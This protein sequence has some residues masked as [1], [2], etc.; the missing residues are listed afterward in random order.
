[1]WFLWNLEN[2]LVTWLLY[3]T[4]VFLIRSIWDSDSGVLSSWPCSPVDVH[5]R[6]G[7]TYCLHLQGSRLSHAINQQGAAGKQSRESSGLRGITA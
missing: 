1:L 2:Y 5:Q 4:E 6:F 7:K 3:C